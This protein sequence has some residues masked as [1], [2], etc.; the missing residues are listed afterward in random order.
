ML[1]QRSGYFLERLQSRATDPKAP[2]V[3]KLASPGRREVTPEMLERRDQPVSSNGGQ[4]RSL[5]L[6]HAFAF[7]AGP[8]LSVLEQSP[9]ELLEPGLEARFGQSL[10]FALAHVVHG[11]I[12][13]LADMK[14]IQNVQRA[15]Q[16][17]PDDCKIR[18]PHV[19]A[20]KADAGTD[21]IAQVVEA[22]QQRLASPVMADPQQPHQVRI[23][24]VDQYPEH[25]ADSH[26]DL[27]DPDGLDV[28]QGP[29]LEP[30][31]DHPLNG[32]V[33]IGPGNLKARGDFIPGELAGPMS[34]EQS[35]AV[36]QPMLAAGPRDFLHDHSA[37][38][39]L[40]SAHRVN[41][42][43]REDPQ[44]CHQPSAGSQVVV[45]RAGPI[46]ATA[47][48]FGTDA[49]HNGDLNRVRQ[50]FGKS[51][52]FI[53]EALDRLH[54]VE[55]RFDCNT[56][57]EGLVSQPVRVGQSFNYLGDLRTA[58]R[59]FN[60]HFLRTKPFLVRTRSARFWV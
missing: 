7:L 13:L 58:P 52:R 29:M 24:L 38:L 2:A 16:P 9:A 23:D 36:T 31:I 41:Q 4:A 51:D 17:L 55:Y 34:Q 1:R 39:A 35:E 53:N 40:N 22:G 5:Q 49:G 21:R 32:G 50:D 19:G 43:H 27:I 15:R 11:L 57:H 30:V 25:P 59:E 45:G 14:A 54:F 10:S 20:D 42:G 28:L 47:P 6:P 60:P 44:G 33:D 37:A 56:R 48:G 8:V 3:Q 18:R 46:T 26:A 12:E